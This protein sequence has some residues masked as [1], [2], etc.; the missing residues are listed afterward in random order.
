MLVC[1]LIMSL[2]ER[3]SSKFH[4]CP[5][6]FASRPNVHFFGQSLS[7]GHYQP[8][9]QPPEGVYLLNIFNVM[10]RGLEML[11]YQLV[12]KGRESRFWIRG[13]L[14]IKTNFPNL[15]INQFIYVHILFIYFK[16]NFKIVVLLKL[17]SEFTN[18]KSKWNKRGK[19]IWLR[20][21][22]HVFKCTSNCRNL[23]LPR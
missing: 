21:V 6:S 2:V 15:L 20:N 14:N 3:L 1:R 5:R 18:N 11:W 22:A 9:Y 8:T 19:L 16:I 12:T 23:L 10:L 17:T 4:I 13:I 7:R